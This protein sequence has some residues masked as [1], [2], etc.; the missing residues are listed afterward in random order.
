MKYQV[1]D[2]ESDWSTDND[3]HWNK[4]EGNNPKKAVGGKKYEKVYIYSVT[5]KRL[6]VAGWHLYVNRRLAVFS[7]WLNS[8]SYIF[9]DCISPS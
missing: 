5:D 1:S 8:N 3:G 9:L 2:S 7:P 6:P 4:D